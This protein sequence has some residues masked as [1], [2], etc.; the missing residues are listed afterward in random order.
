MIVISVLAFGVQN[1]LAMRCVNDLKPIRTVPLVMLG[2]L[3]HL[4]RRIYRL[5]GYKWLLYIFGGWS[6]ATMVFGFIYGAKVAL[7]EKYFDHFSL[8]LT[9]LTSFC[10]PGYRISSPSENRS[11]FG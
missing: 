6:T 2:Q 11:L 8:P 10:N 3:M 7:L 1:F 4:S 5:M 9:P